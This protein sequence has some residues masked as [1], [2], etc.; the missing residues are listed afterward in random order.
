MAP[1][2][3]MKILRGGNTLCLRNSLQISPF[4]KRTDLRICCKIRNAMA[5]S[6]RFCQEYQ[7]TCD[8]Q[9]K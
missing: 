6:T 4:D 1:I 9:I 8:K 2:V 5:F 7:N 3:K